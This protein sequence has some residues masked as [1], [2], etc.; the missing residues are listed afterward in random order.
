[1]D[2][3]RQHAESPQQ[4]RG[5]RAGRHAVRRRRQRRNQLPQLSGAVQPQDKHL[6]G[7]RPHEY[8]KVSLQRSLSVFGLAN[9]PGTDSYLGRL[10]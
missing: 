5:G 4:R 3:H 8:P 2:S 7:R 1:M 10:I 6:G 9:D